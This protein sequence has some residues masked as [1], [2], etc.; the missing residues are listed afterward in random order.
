MV[1]WRR[2]SHEAQCLKNIFSGRTGGTLP[3]LPAQCP[4]STSKETEASKGRDLPEITSPA[5]GRYS[6]GD[7]KSLLLLRE[8][9]GLFAV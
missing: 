6:V 2:E 3:D 1:P 8:S 9:L 4:Y 5:S 7:R